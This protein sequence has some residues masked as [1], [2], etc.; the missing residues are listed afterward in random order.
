MSITSPFPCKKGQ[1]LI[2]SVMTYEVNSPAEV[3]VRVL[4]AK[5]SQVA[6]SNPA[7]A[8]NRFEFT[9]AADGDFVLACEHQNFLH[10]PNEVYYLS[11]VPA[12][13]DFNVA[14]ALDRGE[15]APGNGTSVMATVTRLNGY[16]GPV[17]LSIDGDSALSGKV[18][19]PAGQTFTFIPVMVK[20][21]T[22]LGRVSVPREGNRE[23]RRPDRHALRYAHGCRESELRRNAEPAGRDA[24]SVCTRGDRHAVH[25]EV[26]R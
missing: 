9:P 11:V 21:G 18:T 22:K 15:A 24:E 6:A 17:E 14:V 25:A 8:V 4:D 16:A 19:L 1:K 13:P 26:Y 10:G 7:A 12:A 2:V 23:G 20:D 5:G 3:L